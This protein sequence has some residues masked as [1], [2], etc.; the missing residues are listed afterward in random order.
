[1]DDGEGDGAVGC[2][3]GQRAADLGQLDLQAGADA[4]LEMRRPS[5]MIV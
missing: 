3:S 4:V 5:T 1:M 2:P